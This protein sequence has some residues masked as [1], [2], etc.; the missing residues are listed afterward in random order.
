MKAGGACLPL[1][2]DYPKDRLA[3]MLHDSQVPV[4]ITNSAFLPVFG[5]E[6]RE[7]VVLDST[8]V[9][10]GQSRQN[11]SPI[12]TPDNLAYVIYTS[13]STGKPRGVLLTH[14]GLVNHNVAAIQLYGI[15]P[16]IA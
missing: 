16:T 9:L 12:A 14:R 15:T 3:Y 4:L 2:P 11:L 7:I 6:K 8:Q 10:E 13:G 5:S 1:D